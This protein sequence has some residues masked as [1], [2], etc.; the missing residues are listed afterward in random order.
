MLTTICPFQGQ[1]RIAL[2][3]EAQ[4]GVVPS[5]YTGHPS[6]AFPGGRDYAEDRGYPGNDAYAT[7][8]GSGECPGRPPLTGTYPL[9]GPSG[10]M[11]PGGPHPTGFEETPIY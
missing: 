5:M 9:D 2:P 7:G 3:V 6:Y 11:H 10:L 8:T 4:P 1:G